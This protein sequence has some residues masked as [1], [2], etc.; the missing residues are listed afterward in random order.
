MKLL[1]AED[2]TE[3]SQAL[4]V[5]LEHNGFSVDAVA[6]GAAA[7]KA[8]L[9]G[10]YD[11]MILDIMMPRRDGLEVLSH[12]RAAGLLVPVLMLTARAETSDKIAGLD[13]GADDYLTKPFSMGELLARVRAMTRR[14]TAIA[15]EVLTAGNLKLERA[16]FTLSGAN[17]SIRLSR[18][19]FALLE[20]LMQN[21]GRYLPAARI[22]ERVWGDDS[23]V[24]NSVVWVY[25]SYLRKKLVSVGAAAEIRMLRGR[26]Y[27]LE[28]Q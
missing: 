13:A 12:L 25:I 27:A 6:D 10:Q 11:G 8:G 9:G 15:P 14:Q 3:L 19:E 22:F 7:L 1:L 17:A 24:E 20:L 21:E 2:E 5:I 28:V 18:R 4:K 16:T 26:G 23:E